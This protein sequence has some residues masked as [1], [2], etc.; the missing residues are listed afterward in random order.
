M[1][2][3]RVL[4]LCFLLI[5]DCS[6][7]QTSSRPKIGVALEGGGAK[8]L[9]HIGVLKWFEDHHIP[10]DYI[11]GTSMGGLIGG[12]YATGYSPDEIAEIVKGTD[13]D[14]VMAGRT[15]YPDL[16]FRRKEDLHALANY[17]EFGLR[18]GFQPPGGLNSGQEVRLIID[19][20]V[21][22]YSAV[23]NFDMLPTPFRCVAAD[24]VSGK[25]VIF[26]DGSLGHALRATMSIPGV[27]S[28][29]RENGMV[30]A[31]GGL[32]NNLPTD[33]VKQMGADIVIGVHLS[34]GVVAPENLT[35]LFQVAG[36]ATDVMI[37]ANE[38][39]GIE[40]ADILITVD[41]AG[42]ST[43]A[44]S[45]A[46]RI[47]PLGITA[48]ESKAAV[49][50][51]LSNGE[52]DW[53]R[54]TAARESRKIKEP[55]T[56]GF[57]EVTGT[58]PNVSKGIEEALAPM[59]GKPIDPTHVTNAIRRE[60]GIGRLNSLSYGL[61]HRDGGTGLILN[62]EEKDYAPPWINP[63]ISIDGSDPDNVQFTLGAR[64]T[65]LDVGGYRSELRT[66]FAI[67]SSYTFA[68]EYFHPLTERS[69]WF[70]APYVNV[71]RSPI[72]LYSSTD[73]LAEYK[74]R[75]AGGGIDLGYSFDRFSE[76]RIGYQSGYEKVYLR[77]GSPLLPAVSGRTGETRIRYALDRLDNP[78][79]PRRGVE[80]VA[81]SGY[82]D[83]N[84][85]SHKGIPVGQLL[86][87]GFLPI[88]KTSSI[89]GIVDG[90]TTFGVTH[91]GIPLFSLGGPPRLAA[92]GVN[93]FL[94]DH[95]LYGRLGYLH[96]LVRMPPLI[97]SGLYL[98]AH[99]EAA[100]TNSLFSNTRLPNDGVVGVIA[101]TVLGPLLIGG[102][103]GDAGHQK[104]F[105]Q[106]GRVF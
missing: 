34:T 4:P 87:Q 8:G 48:A 42:Y 96:E 55:P 78:I 19:R 22:P 31:D 62:A 58:S 80:L 56:P 44:F 72:N 99:Y 82:I 32:L 28:P 46:E 83:A 64:I 94:T 65:A 49:L 74:V 3:V 97:G 54:Y 20:Y 63:S 14:R 24:L 68:M 91:T 70:V 101:E 90:A 71:G 76:F 39:R 61:V 10:I 6:A 92:Y 5:G 81:N 73:L 21:L 85:G 50:S 59:I 26:R 66:D 86:V 35:S 40:R 16:A 89:Y 18:H 52:D 60:I 13:W 7:Q 51:R 47:I 95:Y 67:G 30:L 53:K 37:G 25:Q 27:F 105:F 84:P 36:A 79:V 1:R 102:S 93:E 69:L 100:R 104:W 15:D 2:F 43:L 57:I 38:L 106:F 29:V 17:I 23:S 9:A 75:Q 77:V 12:L 88:G 33:V 11:A 41:V 45:R 98:D 103:I